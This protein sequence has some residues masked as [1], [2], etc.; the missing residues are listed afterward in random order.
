MVYD[1]FL[2]NSHAVLT[3]HGI[4]P[5]G[6]CYTAGHGHNP[7]KKGVLAGFR[8]ERLGIQAAKE[9][10]VL[11]LK[12]DDDCMFGKERATKM[13]DD[14]LRNIEAFERKPMTIDGMDIN[15]QI[16]GEFSGTYVTFFLVRSFHPSGPI[17][18]MDVTMSSKDYRRLHER[19]IFQISNKCNLRKIKPTLN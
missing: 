2:A 5:S 10:A 15:C 8:Y 9:L 12:K 1:Y 4:I 7:R 19:A 17:Y 13:H 6:F 11:I 18:T 3:K 14:F 16:Y